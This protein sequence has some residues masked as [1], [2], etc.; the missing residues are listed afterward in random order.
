MPGSA[1]SARMMPGDRAA[2]DPGDDR[3]DQIER[4]DVLVVGR[5][6]PAGEE[7]RLVV[8]VVMRVVRVVG[9]ERKRVGGWCSCSVVPLLILGRR[10]L[11]GRGLP[12]RG[13]GCR[14]RAGRRLGR[15]AA[16]HRGLAAPARRRCCRAPRPARAPGIVPPFERDPGGELRRRHD[17]DRDRHVA[18]AGAAQLGALAEIDARPVDLD[19][20]LVEPAGVG[21]DLDPEGRARRRRG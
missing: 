21:V 20:G 17:L 3:E 2:D 5:H 8:G 16:G 19:P 18:V 6:E 4:A 12:D 10:G 14:R 13:F 7:A 15:A 1:S 11:V 9:L